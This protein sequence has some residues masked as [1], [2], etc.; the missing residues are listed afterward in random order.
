MPR[1]IPA[2]MNH[3]RITRQK[4]NSRVGVGELKRS[5][6]SGWEWEWDGYT[7]SSKRLIKVVRYNTKG[8]CRAKEEEGWRRRSNEHW[9][10]DGAHLQATFS[11]LLDM[12]KSRRVTFFEG[13]GPTWQMVHKEKSFAKKTK[14]KWNIKKAHRTSDQRVSPRSVLV[15][16]QLCPPTFRSNFWKIIIWE[17]YSTCNKSTDTDLLAL[18]APNVFPVF[19]CCCCCYGGA[20]YLISS[21]AQWTLWASHQSFT[22]HS[23][24]SFIVD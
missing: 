14:K 6:S 2:P 22:N 17:R 3:E 21:L 5:S 13:C 18:F 1:P 10:N 7:D 20:P 23:E 15:R 12:F 9:Y 11:E 4:F 8:D 16:R 24:R 19:P